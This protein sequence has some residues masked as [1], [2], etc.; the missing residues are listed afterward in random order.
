MTV[1]LVCFL[2]N[3]PYEVLIEKCKAALEAQAKIGD[4]LTRNE[5]SSS[6]ADEQ[7]A[8]AI[9]TTTTPTTTDY[10]VDEAEDL[11]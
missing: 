9:T 2:H 4:T 1:I 3:K 5:S 11:K 10:I 7:S 6:T 8:P